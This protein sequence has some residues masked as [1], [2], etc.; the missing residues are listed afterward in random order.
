M[1]EGSAAILTSTRT[2]A[3]VPS[4]LMLLILVV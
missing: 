1:G 3:A 4:A 2:E